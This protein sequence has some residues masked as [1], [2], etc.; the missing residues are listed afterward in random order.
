MDTVVRSSNQAFLS[1]ASWLLEWAA[2]IMFIGHVGTKFVITGLCFLRFL[3]LTFKCIK[4]VTIKQ[5]VEY[6]LLGISPASE[7][8]VS[9]FRNLVS[10]PSS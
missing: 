1:D 2:T 6:F 7:L 8:S 5:R 3:V 9:T 10:V 4:F